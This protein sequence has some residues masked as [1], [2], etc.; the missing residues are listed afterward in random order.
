[1]GEEGNGLR[2]VLHA[3]MH[4]SR[5]DASGKFLFDG[6]GREGGRGDGEESFEDERRRHF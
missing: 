5:V 2:R 3:L 6:I 4:I 1:M